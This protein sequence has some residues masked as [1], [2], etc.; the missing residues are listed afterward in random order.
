MNGKHEKKLR[1]IVRKHVQ[2][3]PHVDA[4]IKAAIEDI[5][6]DKAVFE[7]L[8][9][10]LV[11]TAI[12][13][14]VHDIRGS[15]RSALKFSHPR[16]FD[17]DSLA[18]VRHVAIRSF[19][20]SMFFGDRALGDYRG[21]ELPAIAASEREQARGHEMNAAFLEAVAKQVGSALVRKKMTDEQV[22]A[23]FDK[24]HATF[25][26]ARKAG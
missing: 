14:I 24:V 5:R 15:V 20:D 10:E 16:A 22:A 19:L 13:H 6:K 8:L 17:A 12:R 21:D 26:K 9:T 1:S 25:T 4:C 23:L 2:Q 7:A 18:P 3:T 11:E